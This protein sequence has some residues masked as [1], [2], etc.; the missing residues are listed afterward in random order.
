MPIYEFYC[1]DCHRIF[2]FL[3]RRVRPDG[4]PACPACGRQTLERRP[5]SFAVSRGRSEETA[6]GPGDIDE[7]RLERA[8]SSLAAEA[9]QVDEEDSRAMAGLMRKMYDASGLRLGPGMDEAIRRMEAGEDPDQIEDEIGDLLQ[10]EDPF[11]PAEGGR[12]R[13]LGKRLRPP[14]VD[15]TLYEM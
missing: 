11:S 6:D 1:R 2:S 8:M 10:H 4:R 14:T 7:N 13:G 5:S 15:S 3:S 9:E 12:L